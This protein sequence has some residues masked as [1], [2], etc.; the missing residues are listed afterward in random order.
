MPHPTDPSRDL[1]WLMMM[2]LAMPT[3]PFA[4]KFVALAPR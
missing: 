1:L 4:V 3:E 2:D